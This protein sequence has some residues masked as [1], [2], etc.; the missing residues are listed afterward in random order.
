MYC[1]LFIH[2]S[3]DG[4]L[5]WFHV[6]AIVNNVATNIGVH[7]SFLIMVFS[8]YMPRNGIAR[9]YVI[10]SFI[11]NLRT[12]LQNGCTN[13]CL[14]QQHRRVLYSPHSLQHLVFFNIYLCTYLSIWL[15]GVFTA[16]RRISHCGIQA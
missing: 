3:V 14:H 1:I 6:L 16:A 9:S 11:R 15:P 10:F 4:N 7:V 12:V 5:G 2:L 8:G 13:L